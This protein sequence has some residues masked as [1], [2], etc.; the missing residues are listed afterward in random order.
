[1]GRLVMRLPGMQWLSLGMS[2][3]M[4][5]LICEAGGSDEHPCFYLGHGPH[6]SLGNL[7]SAGRASFA[8]SLY[9]RARLY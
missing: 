4:S 1:V 9:R 6:G 7:Q 5:A 8:S 2:G 3:T